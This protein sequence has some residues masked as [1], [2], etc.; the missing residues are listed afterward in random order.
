MSFQAEKTAGEKKRRERSRCSCST[1]RLCTR[2]RTYTWLM[3]TMNEP[4]VWPPMA[5]RDSMAEWLACD[6]NNNSLVAVDVVV[7]GVC[8]PQ[9][10]LVG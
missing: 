3:M 8:L 2:T 5:P 6:L 10:Q 9:H 4:A 7:D 1:D